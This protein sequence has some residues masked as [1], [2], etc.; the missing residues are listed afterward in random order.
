[1]AKLG[2]LLFR[3]VESF[4]SRSNAL[5]RA[6]RPCCERA[7]TRLGHRHS[8]PPRLGRSGGEPAAN[9]RP[10]Q[11]SR[12]LPPALGIRVVRLSVACSISSRRF[13]RKPAGS[14][15][16]TEAKA[17]CNS[18]LDLRLAERANSMRECPLCASWGRSELGSAPWWSSI[19]VE[20]LPPRRSGG[21]SGLRYRAARGG[22][23]DDPVGSLSGC[24]SIGITAAA[25]TPEAAVAG[26]VEALGDSVGAKTK[27]V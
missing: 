6:Q 19:F 20:R 11:P 12:R 21:S 27:F 17:T 14:Q 16:A 3:R 23:A 18:S 13:T 26:V 4:E 2:S 15:A 8:Q 7:H 1:M 10:R 9:F 24:A 5:Q 25:S 22:R